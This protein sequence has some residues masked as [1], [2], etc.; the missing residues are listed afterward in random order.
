MSRPK[1]FF[2][3]PDR[4]APAALAFFVAA[5][6][7]AAAPALAQTAQLAP[8][9]ERI[10]DEAIQRDHRTY[11]AV[12]G[13]IK[14]INDGGRPLR[15][16]ALSKAQCWLDVSLHEYTRNDRSAFPQAALGESEKL[17]A[18]MEAGA[19]PATAET[20]LVNGAARL[21]PDLWARAEALKRAPGY[22]C[23]E[24]K[25]ACAEVEL[26]HAGNEL[27]QQQW[28][29]ANPYVQIAED[30]LAEAGALAS[31]CPADVPQAA[32][33][34]VPPVAAPAAAPPRVAGGA[35][36]ALT[37]SVVFD[38]NRSGL[39]DIRPASAARLDA[40]LA[41]IDSERLAIASIRLAGHADRL[42][43]TGNAAYNQRLSEK[44]V[45]TVRERLIGRG[46]DP[47]LVSAVARGD[48]QP[49]V[50]CGG[51]RASQAELIECLLPNRR[52]DVV[53][54]AAAA[55]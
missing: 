40:L 41:R 54:D 17:V 51:S 33:G 22:A 29:H 27:N 19:P 48:S 25:V 44:R 34:A 45:A 43:G 20:P 50:A 46:I 37:A 38:F 28:R 6:G 18:A 2:R 16:Y 15:D 24:Q 11:E 9:A 30:L 47:A 35:S 23:A 49:V 13:R 32:A 21:R 55:K 36:I 7:A 53:I 3:T 4:R 31:R 52:V 10:S 26:V 39:R 8:P 1:P 14:S 42:N 5:L 12:Q